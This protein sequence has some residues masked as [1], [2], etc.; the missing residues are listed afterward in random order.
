MKCILLILYK[1]LLFLLVCNDK[2]ISRIHGKKLQNL[3]FNTYYDNSVLS[4]NA[5]K[6][7]FIFSSYIWIDH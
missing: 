3:F 4:H 2:A 1:P 6:V 5:D 7:I